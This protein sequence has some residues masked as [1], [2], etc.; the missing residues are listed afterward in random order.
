M[1]L[2]SGSLNW[3]FD[4]IVFS[5]LEFF[6]VSNLPSERLMTLILALPIFLLCL[7]NSLQVLAP[8][9][10]VANLAVTASVGIIFYFCSSYLAQ[11]V[12]NASY[13]KG[14]SSS[15]R[16]KLKFYW[17]EISCNDFSMISRLLELTRI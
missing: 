5:V 16:R 3:S 11:G 15:R 13:P 1:S 8:F 4:C 2:N 14:S 6:N 12:H 9:S 7:I 10:M 17:L